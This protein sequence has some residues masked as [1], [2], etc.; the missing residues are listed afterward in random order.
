MT[1]NCNLT[2]VLIGALLLPII[3]I[4][5]GPR[6]SDKNSLD[7]L[8]VRAEHGDAAAQVQLGNAYLGRVIQTGVKVQP[9][10]SEAV[11]W[12]LAA[13]EKNNIEALL[14]LGRGYE[15]GY[16]CDADGSKAVEYFRRAAERTQPVN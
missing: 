9:S 16:L 8:L 7:D 5:Q 12:F 11:R 10:T 3:C 6:V 14:E 2:V 15:Y 13:T 4:A 1:R